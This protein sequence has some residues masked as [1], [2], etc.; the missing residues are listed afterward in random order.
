[1]ADLFAATE[2]V[3]DDYGDRAGGFDCWQKVKVGDG[4]G[5]LEFVLLKAEWAGH[6]TAGGVDELDLSAGFAEQREF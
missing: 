1:M 2:S 3:G 5:K 6:A 4:F